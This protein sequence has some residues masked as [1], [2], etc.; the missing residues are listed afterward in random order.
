MDDYPDDDTRIRGWLFD[1][2][3]FAWPKNN[4]E[5]LNDDQ[6]QELVGRLLVQKIIGLKGVL[7]E[8]QIKEAD[9]DEELPAKK[10]IKLEDDD[11]VK[12]VEEKKVKMETEDGEEEQSVKAES[13]D[14]AQR[15][16]G[17]G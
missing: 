4:Y 7:K 8:S 5:R 12:Q 2:A 13:E 6:T 16:S 17:R 14:G 10:K 9:E 1:Y 11:G 15:K 3:Q